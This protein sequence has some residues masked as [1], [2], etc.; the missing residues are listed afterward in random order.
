MIHYRIKPTRPQAH[1]LE[2]CLTVED[3]DPQGQML[4]LPAWIRGSYMVR[5]FARNLVMLTAS[6]EGESI[7]V[8]KLDKQTWQVAPVQGPLVVTYS[9]YAWDLSVRGAHVDTTHAYFNGPNVFLGVTGRENEPCRVELLRPEGEAYTDWRLAVSMPP[10]EVDAAG[11]GRYFAE[12]YESLLDYPFEMGRFELAEFVVEKVPHKL[13]VSGRHRLDLTRICR[14]LELI[15]HEEAALFSDLPIDDYLFLLWVEGEGYGGLEHRNSCSLM[16]GRDEL[17][18]AG[19]T[20]MIKGYRRLLG[21]FSHEYFHLW[22]VK[23]ITPEVF[24]KQDTRQEVYTRQLWIFEGITSYYDE[25]VLVRS[26]VID[27]NNYFEMVAE[28]ITRVMRGSGRLKQTL[29]ESSFDAWTK[30]Y[31]Q[32]ENAP[33]AIVSY[34]AKGALLAM[35]LDLTIRLRTDGGMSL[36][37]VMRA[38]WHR[39]GRQGEGLPETG[40]ELLVETLTGLDFKAFFDAG[41]RST[42]DLPLAETLREFGVGLYLLPASSS[43]DMGG[44]CEKSPQEA[45]AKPVLGAKW[46]QKGDSVLLQQVFDDGAAQLAGLSAGDEVIAVDGLRLNAGRLEEYVEQTPAGQSLTFHLFRRNELMCFEVTPSPAPAD[47][48]WFHLIESID[49]VKRSRRDNWLRGYA[50][51][52]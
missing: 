46:M 20:K 11:F 8:T 34:Y 9:V 3:T 31:K 44:V 45:T 21:L 23:R 41:V 28:G 42:D 19:M 27:R 24:L 48:C 5:D 14:D 15:C 39:Y 30:F 37:D 32:D 33:N 7:A 18:T 1:M 38:L 12:D 25:L 51:R 52:N 49:D 40:F 4:Y 47:T 10:V 29:A 26:G 22:N 50:N 35:L 17:P 13:V 36:D 43:S 6:C 2:V 16:I